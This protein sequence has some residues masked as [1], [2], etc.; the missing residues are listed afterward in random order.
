MTTERVLSVAN[1]M[2]LE[3]PI[4][5]VLSYRIFDT[6]YV[7]H[8]TLYIPAVSHEQKNIGRFISQLRK[9]RGMTQTELA[10]ALK[11]S[12]S[13]VARME[14][15]EQ[16][17]S[18]DMLSKISEALHKEIV[19]LGTGA[20]NFRIHGGRKL[21]G[22]IDVRTAKNSAVGVLCASLLN[23]GTTTIRN[24]PKIEEV[25]RIIE[26]LQSIGVQ[27]MW[28]DGN[29]I[30]KPP[31]TFALSQLDKASA[32]K[33][34]SIVMLMGSL[35]HHLKAFSLPYAGGCKLGTRTVRPHLFALEEFGVSIT[36][37]DDTY[38]V[39]VSKRHAATVVL[40]ET[41][42]TVTENALMA[43]AGILEESV[44]KLASA[45]YMVQDVC[46]F[47]EKLGVKI[48]G[49]GTSTLRVRGVRNINLDVSYDLSEDPIEAM[50]LLTAAIVTKSSMT[51]KRCPIDFLELEMLK[52]EKMGFRYKRSKPYVSKNGRTQ[53]VDITTYPSKLVALKEKIHSQPFPGI[54]MDNL[55]FFVPIA[56]MAEGKTLIRDWT[57]ENRAIYFTE[58]NKVGANVQLIDVH[59]AYV[60]GPTQWHAAEHI[61]PPALRPGMVILLG[62]LAAPGVSILRNVYSINRG[63][64]DIA[65]RLNKLGAKIEVLYGI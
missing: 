16:N 24:V 25:H 11:T 52:L 31:K 20:V 47:L 13:A 30:I 8:H 44:I 5:P 46:F 54:N 34:R 41:G 37:K 1:L 9:Q 58:L 53:L 45:N 3:Y 21:K 35:M 2:I 17:F 33:T 42:D 29:V 51:V 18:L 59:R 50:S 40:Y 19:T 27:V 62:M 36:T 55:P 48:D 4:K 15:G 10:K 39:T 6:S 43:A 64:E 60:E 56:A 14:R 22:S 65:N 28:N 57:Y 12:Q 26:V 7:I 63:Y 49:I 38:R 61:C 23:K 32:A